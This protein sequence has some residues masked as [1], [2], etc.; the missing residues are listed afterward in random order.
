VKCNEAK[1]AGLLLGITPIT[2]TATGEF[3]MLG[4]L[5]NLTSGVAAVAGNAPGSYCWMWIPVAAAQKEILL[6][7]L[8]FHLA[9]A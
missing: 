3:A 4:D 2:A 8:L 1:S 6:R 5:I 9:P 7:S